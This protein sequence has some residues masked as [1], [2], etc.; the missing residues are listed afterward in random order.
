MT[1]ISAYQITNVN[2]IVSKVKTA[3]ANVFAVPAFAPAV[4]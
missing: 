1:L 3:M 2:N 4:A